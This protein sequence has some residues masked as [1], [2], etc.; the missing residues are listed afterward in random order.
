MSTAR[1]RLTAALAGTAIAA[2]ALAGCASSD[3]LSDDSN[4]S[5]N[6]A[7][8]STIVIG[9]QAY[10]SNE[11]IAEIYAQALEGAGFTVERNFNIGQRDVYIPSLEDGSIDLFPEYTGNLLQFFD[12]QTTATTSDDVYA[13]LK[14][15]LPDGLT[16]LDQSPATDQDSYNVTAA[17]AEENGLTSIEDLA[18]IEGLVLGGAPELE[19]RPY[20]P[21][22]LKDLYNVDVA[23]SATADTTVDELVAGNIQVAN[24]YSA[25][26]RIK[27]D[28]LVTLEDP[29]GLFLASNVVPV[30]NADIADE[31]ADVINAVSA[32]L[33]PEGLVALNVESTVDQRS[34]EDIA[35]DWLADNGLS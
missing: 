23:F 26:P 10:Y 12:P 5:G 14:D 25:D 27:T 3:P 30:V 33:T 6:T 2:L 19:E 4:D 32:A 17:F 11:I 21:K 18:G 34:S 1:T 29:K 24:V 22:G 35:K 20:G 28:D 15:A 7:D 8:S 31:I 13:A 9:S 16:V